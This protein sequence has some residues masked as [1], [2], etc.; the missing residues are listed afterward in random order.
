M[1]HTLT[2]TGMKPDDEK[3]KAITEF[4]ASHDLHH[5]RYFIG[6]VKI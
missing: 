5:L 4:L 2:Y 1:G 3:V 6:M